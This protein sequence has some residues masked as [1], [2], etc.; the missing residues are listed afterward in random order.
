MRVFH[1]RTSAVVAR[2]ERFAYECIHQQRHLH[3]TV[4]HGRVRGGHEFS[5]VHSGRRAVGP[6]AGLT[7][8]G[9]AWVTCS[10]LAGEGGN[11]ESTVVLRAAPALPYYRK[12]L[13][14]SSARVQAKCLLQYHGRRM[15][16]EMSRTQQLAECLI[17]SKLGMTF[18]GDCTLYYYKV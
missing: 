2:E 17:I 6:W 8:E 11:W 14:S 13:K 18:H 7:H 1:N 15:V 12:R 16:E 3:L 10:L 9:E 5:N 4:D